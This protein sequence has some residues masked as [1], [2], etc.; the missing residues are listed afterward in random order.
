M[1]NSRENSSDTL[2]LF[3][4]TWKKNTALVSYEGYAV[5]I[6][7]VIHEMTQENQK[8]PQLWFQM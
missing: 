2:R 1:T 7:K 5:Q 8:K 3:P 4:T 6:T